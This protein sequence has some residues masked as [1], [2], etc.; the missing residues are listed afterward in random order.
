MPLHVTYSQHMRIN[1]LLTLSMYKQQ[2]KCDPQLHYKALM[3]IVYHPNDCCVIYNLHYLLLYIQPGKQFSEMTR[4][5]YVV[6]LLVSLLWK[7]VRRHMAKKYFYCKLPTKEEKNIMNETCCNSGRFLRDKNRTRLQ[8]ITQ[9]IVWL[10]QD[11]EILL[12]RKEVLSF[13]NKVIHWQLLLSLPR[14]KQLGPKYS[15]Y[16]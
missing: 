9:G 2:V 8:G 6:R 10:V 7:Q 16:S 12:A 4:L 15:N 14:G 11:L 3:Y 5:K 13:K 1:Q